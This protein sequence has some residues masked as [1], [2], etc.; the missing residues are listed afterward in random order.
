MNASNCDYLYDHFSPIEPLTIAG[1][2]DSTERDCPKLARMVSELGFENFKRHSF[3][4]YTR[5]CISP[6]E[7]KIFFIN[8][9]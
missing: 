6:Q 3:H 9:N 2:M 5:L 8:T 7:L 1:N 4:K